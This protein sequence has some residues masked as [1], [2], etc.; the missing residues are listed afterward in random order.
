MNLRLPKHAVF[1][2]LASALMSGSS[3]PF[4]ERYFS[5]L[6]YNSGTLGLDLK[7][8]CK[9]IVYTRLIMN[10]ADNGFIY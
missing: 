9:F 2:C 6:G 3:Q 8:L 7:L 1:S 10:V 5:G 4:P